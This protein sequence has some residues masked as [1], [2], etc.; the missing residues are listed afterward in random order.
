MKAP[1]YVLTGLLLLCMA[2]PAMAQRDMTTV[3]GTITDS[4][5]AVIPGAAITITEEATGILNRVESDAA[6]NYIRPVLKP[7]TYTIEVEVTG[8][9]KAANRIPRAT[10]EQM[11]LQDP[12]SERAGGGGGRRRPA[13]A[14]M[15][16]ELPETARVPS[17][18]W[19]DA[20]NTKGD[21]WGR[22]K[23]VPISILGCWGTGASYSTACPLINSIPKTDSF[24]IEIQIRAPLH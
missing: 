21:T 13:S 12:A 6:G 14:V 16:W 3:L 18:H 8:F 9:K 22:G 7:G 11:P 5:G 20:S 23:Q 24:S 10:P 17:S 2:V 15:S 4:T 19:L 1:T